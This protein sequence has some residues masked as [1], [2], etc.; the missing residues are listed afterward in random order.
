MKKSKWCNPYAV[1]KYGL[2]ECLRMYE[3]HVRRTPELLE[4]IPSL[5]GHTLGCWCKGKHACHGD[6]LVKLF[7]ELRIE[8]VD[9][10]EEDNEEGEDQEEEEEHEEEG[11]RRMRRRSQR[12]EKKEHDEVEEGLVKEGS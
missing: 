1:K 3:A 6:V 9:V 7:N 2:K 10:L 12:M 11:R 4:A 8:K 5:S